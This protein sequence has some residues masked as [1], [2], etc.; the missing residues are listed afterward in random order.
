VPA[1]A[2][3]LIV[4]LVDYTEIPF[5][6]SLG[7]VLAMLSLPLVAA[8]LPPLL[9]AS[10]TMRRLERRRLRAWAHAEPPAMTAETPAAAAPG[11]VAGAV[12]EPGGSA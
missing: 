10:A 7:L 8:T 5:G 2:A 9:A 3:G 6:V 4:L 12:L 1:G 11:D